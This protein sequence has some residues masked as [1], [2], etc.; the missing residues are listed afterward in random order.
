MGRY[1]KSDSNR[2][3]TNPALSVLTFNTSDELLDMLNYGKARGW[4]CSRSEG[5][6][7][8]LR[9]GLAIILEEHESLNQKVVE[10][11]RS[12]DEL[13][14]DK[15]YVKIPGRGYLEIIDVA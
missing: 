7:V 4:W 15:E 1:N 12:Q 8:A 11:L 2:S 3:G 6:R 14:P 10:N 5:M 13:N 9:R